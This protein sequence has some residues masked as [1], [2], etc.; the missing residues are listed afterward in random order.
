MDQR[1]FAVIQSTKNTT[2]A[3]RVIRFHN[4]GLVVTDYADPRR[5]AKAHLI[6]IEQA[7][8]IFMHGLLQIFSS[9]LIRGEC[10]RV[11]LLLDQQPNHA[12]FAPRVAQ[13]QTDL[14]LKP[15]IRADG[16]RTKLAVC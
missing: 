16:R 8:G 12:L 15:G 11:A 2:S 13:L 10:V 3:V 6:E 14:P 4:T 7:N 9:G 5:S 1:V